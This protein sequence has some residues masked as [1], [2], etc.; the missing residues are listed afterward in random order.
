MGYSPGVI[1]GT[2]A[3]RP[4]GMPDTGKAVSPGIFLLAT[5][6]AQAPLRGY[7]L[8][9]LTGMQIQP[10]QAYKPYGNE[11]RCFQDHQPIKGDGDA[12]PLRATAFHVGGTASTIV[13]ALMCRRPASRGR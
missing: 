10:M 11:I 1:V 8:A 13:R 3:V 5:E 7:R 9:P 6:L 4:F 12:V 2:A